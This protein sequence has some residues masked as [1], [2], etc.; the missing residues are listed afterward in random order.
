MNGQKSIYVKSKQVRIIC[1]N[2]KE[3]LYRLLFTPT[4]TTFKGF[5]E[6]FKIAEQNER[7]P[8]NVLGIKGNTELICRRNRVGYFRFEEDNQIAVDLKLDVEEYSTMGV[9]L[10]AYKG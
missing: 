9:K 1:I 2:K 5:I 7:M 4:V 8:I 3:S 6:I 10:Y